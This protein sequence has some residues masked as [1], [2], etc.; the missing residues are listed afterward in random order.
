VRFLAVPANPHD[1]LLSALHV[2][3][4][5]TL[6]YIYFSLAKLFFARLQRSFATHHIPV[7]SLLVDRYLV[8][9]YKPSG[10]SHNHAIEFVPTEPHKIKATNHTHRDLAEYRN[11]A[12]I[13]LTRYAKGLDKARVDVSTSNRDKHLAGNHAFYQVK[14]LILPSRNDDIPDDALVTFVDTDYY[15]NNLSI[16]AGH[17]MAFYTFVPSKICGVYL[18]SFYTHTD[19]STVLMQVNGGANYRHKIWDF[20]RD[21]ITLQK[22]SFTYVYRVDRI[23]YGPGHRFVF[24]TLKAKVL[25]PMN[26][27]GWLFGW[28]DESLQRSLLRE[29]PSYLFRIV[30]TPTPTL[31][32]SLK[33]SCVSADIP[34]EVFCVLRS[35]FAI[36]KKLDL[37]EINS[38]WKNITKVGKKI[39]HSY[40]QMAQNVIVS[41]EFAE[42]ELLGTK[43]N[44]SDVLDE[45]PAYGYTSDD[46][47]KPSKPALQQLMDPVINDA[48]TN[49]VI[50]DAAEIIAHKERVVDNR[51][52]VQFTEAVKAYGGE[53]KKFLLGNKRGI[54]MGYSDTVARQTRKAQQARN[55]RVKFILDQEPKSEV[56]LK[57]DPSAVDDGQMKPARVITT[58]NTVQCLDLSSYTYSFKELVLKRT[59][60]YASCWTPARIEQELTKFLT[61]HKN[62]NIAETDQSKFDAHI[63]A[64]CRAFEKDIYSTFFSSNPEFGDIYDKD[65]PKF[66]VGKTSRIKYMCGS[67]R[68]SG[69]ALTTDGNGI[70]NAF[71]SYVSHRNNGVKPSLAWKLLGPKSGDD[72]LDYGDMS[73]FEAGA[74]LLGFKLTGRGIVDRTQSVSFLGRNYVLTPSGVSSIC[75]VPRMLRKLHLTS[76]KNVTKLQGFG[77]KVFGYEV[78]DPNTPIVKQLAGLARRLGCKEGNPNKDPE[79][80]RKVKTGPFTNDICTDDCI[81]MIAE[82]MQR[83]EAEICEACTRID[84]TTSL[85]SL[86]Q[87]FAGLTTPVR[88]REPATKV[89]GGVLKRNKS[90]PNSKNNKSKKHGKSKKKQEPSSRP[91]HAP[92]SVRQDDT[93]QGTSTNTANAGEC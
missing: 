25:N 82:S 59:H 54:P 84:N 15:L 64:D 16:Y 7:F 65:L 79:L 52:T 28:Q 89:A 86:G 49:F 81:K 4:I 21:I 83:S 33:G 37:G 31:Q 69:S 12:S 26:I 10:R 73:T 20:D 53:F 29:T 63:S 42:V 55:D 14:D 11:S 44:Y 75:D 36:T 58:A 74:N 56:F 93:I 92:E 18:D 32:V 13:N 80:D 9:R 5:F 6:G 41:K 91:N 8:T 40:I 27:L 62:Y 2:A 50:N 30:F 22:G 78:T 88:A 61:S 68:H 43:F 23:P 17:D 70:I 48:D 66:V 57:T 39:N 76:N 1:K 85:A 77:N 46:L 47:C 3:V 90:K 24:L 87:V 71:L 35:K 67:E 38:L 45:V 60:W 72:S 34:T 51:N 19:P